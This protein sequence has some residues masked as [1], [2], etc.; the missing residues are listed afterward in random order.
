MAQQID[1]DLGMAYAKLQQSLR[2]YLRRRIPDPTQAEDLLQNIFLKA[3]TTNHQDR[4]I[5]S[6]TGWL[7]AAARTALIDYY[8]GRGEPLQQLDDSLTMQDNE[9]IQLHAQLSDCLKPFIQQLP[10]IYRDTLIAT[11]IDGRTM[12]ALADEQHLSV[13]AVKS[14]ASRARNMLKE[15]LLACCSVDMVDGLVSD[16]QHTSPSSCSNKCE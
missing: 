7:Y 8:R 10:S 12:R 15:K 16:Y 14:R 1:N 13:S 2:S 3:L 6:L 11:D 4:Q 9:D 5:R